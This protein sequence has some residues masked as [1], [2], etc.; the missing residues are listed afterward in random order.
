MSLTLPEALKRTRNNLFAGMA[1]AIVT[2]DELAAV[3]PMSP[4]N[5][6]HDTYRREGTLPGTEYIDDDGITTEESTGEDDNVTVPLRR[7]VGNLDVDAFADDLTGA[8]PGSQRGAQVAKKAKTTWRL[9]KDKFVNGA[10][11]TS[12]TFV[13]AGAPFTAITAIDYGPWLDSG[14]YGPAEV[15]YDHAGTQW[16]FRAPGDVEFGDYVV[17]SADGAF[18]L[19]S[20]NRSKYITCTI[21]VS[22]AVADGRSTITFASTSKESDGLKQII[23]PGMTIDP[24]GANGD[25][26]DL[27]MLDKMITMEKV[28]TNLVFFCNG[29]IIEKFYAA[30]RAL[31]GTDPR[32]VQ[33][34]GYGTPVPTYRGI[35]LL[36]NDNVLSDETVGSLTDGSSI[37]LASLDADEGLSLTVANTGGTSLNV[38]ADPRANIVMG[39]RIEELGAL[40]G[41]DARR[42]RVKFYSAPRLKSTLALVRK[43]GIITA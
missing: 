22:V 2:T 27:G 10:N 8:G 17:A 9:V 42:I 24:V 4:V 13:V 11:T 14:R 36:Q 41:K 3:M 32:T 12:H 1:K 38:D 37:W 15:Q 43:R 39:F 34:P 5:S 29:S 40:E 26:F 30:Y 23:G 28:R 18:T 21:D 33:L 25:A 6:V 31:G 7:I 16:R 20:W 35:P 19:R